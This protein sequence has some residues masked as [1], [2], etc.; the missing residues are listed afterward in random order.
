MTLDRRLAGYLRPMNRLLVGA[1]LCGLSCIGFAQD[2]A[3]DRT[4]LPQGSPQVRARMAKDKAPMEAAWVDSLIMK[5][6]RSSPPTALRFLEYALVIADSVRDR[7]LERDLLYRLSTEQ[8][9]AGK[10]KPALVS[11]RAAHFLKD[12]LASEEAERSSLHT[13]QRF[14]VQRRE[15]QELQ[16][17]H[18]EEINK[19][20]EELQRAM[21]RVRMVN[22]TAAVVI[23]I[24]LITLTLSLI[25]LRRLQRKPKE[26]ATFA[27]TTELPILVEPKKN[28]LRPGNVAPAPESDTPVVQGDPEADMLRALFRKRMP[29]RLQAL[30]EARGRGD[31]EK[32]GRVLASMRPQLAQHDGPLFTERCSRLL[33]ARE[34]VLSAEHASDLDRLI[35]DVEQALLDPRP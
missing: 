26:P 8:E 7:V 2:G 29:E 19:A 5:A 12:S 17:Q 13:T 31:H 14:E 1:F 4:K 10:S 15:L 32:V 30:K 18:A 20:R 35:A 22:I 24:L 27:P 25:R 21:E 34:G 28:T 11:L 33:E 23:A 3:L 16:A 6:E 9:R